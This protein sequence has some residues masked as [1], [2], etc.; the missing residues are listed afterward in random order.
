MEGHGADIAFTVLFLCT[1]AARFLSG[2]VLAVDGAGSADQLKLD[3]SSLD[4]RRA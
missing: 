4:P 2:Q 3:L 1:P